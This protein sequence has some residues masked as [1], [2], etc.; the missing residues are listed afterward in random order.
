MRYEM[1][2]RRRTAARKTGVAEAGWLRL[3]TLEP[4]L[5]LSADLQPAGTAVIEQVINSVQ[6]PVASESLQLLIEGPGSV[7]L[8]EDDGRL[9]LRIDGSTEQT[10][11]RTDPAAAARQINGIEAT[12]ALGSLELANL[13]LDGT[14]HFAAGIQLIRL[15]DLHDSHVQLDGSGATR[16]EAGTV[17]D[18]QVHAANVALALSAKQWTSSHTGTSRIDAASLSSL[19]ITG[20]LATDLYL[21]GQ[22]A[23]AYTLGTVS[24]G[25]QL[26]D[27]LWAIH[28]RA[29]TINVCAGHGALLHRCKSYGQVFAEPKAR[30]RASAS[31]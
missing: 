30:R 1:M 17:R 14:A 4:R 24:I 8:L 5:L 10:H 19:T 28:G 15:G 21:S 25:G 23:P 12:S 6:A 27:G 22:G 7:Q 18:T 11:I 3:E 29:S 26:G 9:L 31:L 13:T 16:L 2:F 20:D